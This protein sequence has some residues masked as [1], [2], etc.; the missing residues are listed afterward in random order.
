MKEE[1]N[2]TGTAK[3][4]HVLHTSQR[5]TTCYIST[6]SYRNENTSAKPA[7]KSVRILELLQLAHEATNGF[8]VLNIQRL[9]AKSN[10][11]DVNVN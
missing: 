11:S 2:V 6:E 5:K 10:K 1:N 8:T 9:G 7:T 4:F 3:Y